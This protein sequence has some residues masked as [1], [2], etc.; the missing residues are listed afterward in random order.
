[1][2]TF[3]GFSGDRTWLLSFPQA[4]VLQVSAL[5]AILSIITGLAIFCCQRHT[6]FSVRF[7]IVLFFL[8]FLFVTG[9][10]CVMAL[11]NY[12]VML[13]L[14]ANQSD[15]PQTAPICSYYNLYL[16]SSAFH[17][18][19]FIIFAFHIRGTLSTLFA[20]CGSTEYV[21][22]SQ[23]IST[24]NPMAAVAGSEMPHLQPVF[25]PPPGFFPPPPPPLPLPECSK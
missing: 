5:G 25:P 20:W 24:S 3:N 9:S 17:L 7:R 23:N 14:P 6:V 18:L 10:I 11:V 13:D 15:V 1:M 19:C 16:T 21:P 2:T 22:G 4:A 8:H 12:Q